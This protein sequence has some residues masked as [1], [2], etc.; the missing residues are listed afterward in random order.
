MSH[1]VAWARSFRDHLSA[2]R[3]L[4]QAIRNRVTVDWASVPSLFLDPFKIPP[5]VEVKASL[6]TNTG[7]AHRSRGPGAIQRVDLNPFRSGRR[8]QELVFEMAGDLT[9]EYVKSGSCEAPAHVLFPQLVRIVRAVRRR[10]GHADQ[11]G[12]TSG[13]VPVAVLRLGDRASGRVHSS[14]HVAGRS[15]RGS[16][17]RNQP[18][19]WFHGGRRLLDEQGRAR[20]GQEPRELRRR[21]HQRSGSSRRPTSSTRTRPSRRSSRTPASASPSPTSTTASRTTT[22]R[23]SSFD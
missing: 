11:A 18:R 3:R 14:G 19:T 22:C 5:E 13:S 17:L 7:P 23:T 4:S 8:I 2:C 15:A 6:Q 21:R 9:R 16:A 1:A 10:E 20:G 12:G